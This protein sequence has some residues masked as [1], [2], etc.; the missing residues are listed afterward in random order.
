MGQ[1]RMVGDL[2]CPTDSAVHP[3][4]QRPDGGHRSILRDR[5]R[6]RPEARREGA[7]REEDGALLC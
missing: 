4:E 1:D 6:T 5:L 7:S 3:M 2:P